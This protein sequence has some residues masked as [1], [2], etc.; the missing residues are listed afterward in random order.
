MELGAP[1]GRRAEIEEFLTGVRHVDVGRT[2]ATVLCTD[3]VGSSALA[4][5]IGDRRWRDVL[6]R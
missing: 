1:N 6:V 5:T 2:P 3:I 4:A